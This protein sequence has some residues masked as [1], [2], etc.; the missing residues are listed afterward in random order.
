MVQSLPFGSVQVPVPGFGA[1]GLSFA[2]GNNLSLEEAEPVLLKAIE[3]GCT[4]WDTAVVYRA[5]VNEKLLGDFIRKHNV[6]DK[7]FIASKCGFNVFDGE[8]EVTNSAPHI[9]EYIEGTIER[10]GFTPDLYYL[11]RIDP[12]TP[13]EESIPALD[14]IRK[15]GKTKYIGLSECSPATLRKANSIAKIDAIQ[16][17]Y[18]AFETLHETDGLIDTA[19]QLGVAYVAYSPLGRGWLVDD[20]PYKTPEDFSPDDFRRTVPKFQGENFYKNRAIVDEIKKLAAKKGCTITQV[21]L[22]WVAAQGFIAI[23]GT[24]KADRLEVNWASRN[25]ELS[26]DE[27]RE[28]RAIIDAA[29]PHGNRYAPAAQ[30]MVGH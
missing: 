23:P 24:S 27:K 8:G 2:L 21:A 22:A 12:K 4:F 15:A 17:E 5:G 3:L 30:A 29:K 26:D 11:H 1:M 19:R 28:M 7:I 20:F 10:L 14:E 16:A 13:L 25:I 6:R 9:K 18:S